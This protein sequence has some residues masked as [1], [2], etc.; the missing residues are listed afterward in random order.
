[1]RKSLATFGHLGANFAGGEEAR[2]E[3]QQETLKKGLADRAVTFTPDQLQEPLEISFN[4]S[5]AS[6]DERGSKLN[7]SRIK[8]NCAKA[9]LS[10]QVPVAQLILFLSPHTIFDSN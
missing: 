2:L 5:H 4:G 3:S 8:K 6:I 10:G 1:M 9:G 7:A